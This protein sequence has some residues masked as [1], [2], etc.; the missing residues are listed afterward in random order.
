M[1]GDVPVEV[2]TFARDAGKVIEEIAT[3]HRLLRADVVHADRPMMI[4]REIDASMPRVRAKRGVRGADSGLVFRCGGFVTHEA[5]VVPKKVRVGLI[6]DDPAPNATT[7][8]M[9][10]APALREQ[11]HDGSEKAILRVRRRHREF[12][13]FAMPWMQRDGV[14]GLVFGRI[15]DDNQIHQYA[16]IGER[17][18]LRIEGAQIALI[19]LPNALGR[20]ASRGVESGDVHI[21]ASVMDA[22]LQGVVDHLNL[23]SFDARSHG[24]GIRVWST[25]FRRRGVLRFTRFRL[26]PGLRTGDRLQKKRGDEKKTNHEQR[27]ACNQ[28]A[29][30]ASRSRLRSLWQARRDAIRRRLDLRH[31]LHRARLLLRRVVRRRMRAPSSRVVRSARLVTLMPPREVKCVSGHHRIVFRSHSMSWVL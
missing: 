6:P 18:D 21:H 30:G 17:L 31:L 20:F 10:A 13:V 12:E 9:C 22:E 26:K 25:A 16:S 29:A 7:F 14:H 8:R 4:E 15:R 24:K 28:A 23:Q 19:P 3:R 1:P 2:T 5:H 11:V 27:Y